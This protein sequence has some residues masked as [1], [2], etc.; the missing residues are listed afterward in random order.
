MDLYQTHQPRQS[1]QN[2]MSSGTSMRRDS[3]HSM[4]DASD[5]LP[6]AARFARTLGGS[7]DSG[8]VLPSNSSK[9]PQS[10]RQASLSSQHSM[11]HIGLGIDPATIPSIEDDAD[12]APQPSEDPNLQ[13][14]VQH[15]SSMTQQRP[16]TS[17][18]RYHQPSSTSLKGTSPPAPPSRDNGFAKAQNTFRHHLKSLGPPSHNKLHRSDKAVPQSERA[19]PR[20]PEPLKI[21]LTVIMEHLLGRHEQLSALL[22]ER[23]VAQY[24]LVRSL[25]DIWVEQVSSQ[26]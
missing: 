20:L 16:P 19:A 2:T 10:H 22:Q 4:T 15:K 23:W 18:S 12:R 3:S 14:R 11:Q 1:T 8:L 7:Q 9:A 25:S 5:V 13:R 24:P 17:Q 21:L 6:I 26:E